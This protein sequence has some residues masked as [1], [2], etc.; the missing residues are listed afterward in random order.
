MPSAL[1]SPIDLGPVHMKNRI[2][3]SPMCQYSADDGCANDWHLMH[4][5]Q[6]AISGAGLVMLEATHV[7]RQARITHGCLGLYSDANEAALV[8]VMAAVRHVARPGARWG[9]QLNHAGRKASTQRP[10]EGRGPLVPNEDPWPTDAPSALPGGRGWHVPAQMTRD[11]MVR[12]RGQFVAAAQRA[13][14]LGFDVVELHAAHGYLLH[15]F[16]TPLAN[17][18][19]DEYG[20]TLEN[21]MRFPLEVAAAIREV[22]PPS[23]AF[24]ARITG[25]DWLPEGIDVGEAAIFAQ[26][27]QA[28]GAAYVCVSSGGAAFADIP[29]APGYQVHLAAEVKAKAGILTRAVGMNVDP[30]QAEEIISSGAADM[31]ALAR[32]MLDNPR[33]AWHAAQALGA[34]GTA[35]YPP[36]Y[37][38]TRPD[39]WPGARIARPG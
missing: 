37:E 11:D 18:R 1:F 7:A 33:W 36:Q 3:V 23:I 19:Q 6:F 9:I 21:R 39:L 35:F 8:R 4:L 32:A 15:E 29:V 10:W 34:D 17:Q 25:T 5:M 20:G 16:L 22:L 27:L 26:K 2:V 14:R 38:R 12:V 30:A 28:L 31:V 13:T 24:G